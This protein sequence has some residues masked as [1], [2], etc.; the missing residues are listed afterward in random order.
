MRLVLFSIINVLAAL[1][2]GWLAYSLGHSVGRIVLQVVVV[3][4]ALQF[5]Y[6]AWLVVVSLLSSNQSNAA[7]KP[8]AQ[9]TAKSPGRSA[10]SGASEGNGGSAS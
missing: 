2:F 5:A 1:V 4:V 10:V 9:D 3:V 8:R 7:Q 6:A